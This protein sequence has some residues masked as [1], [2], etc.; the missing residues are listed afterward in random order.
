MLG[1]LLR[2]FM[3]SEEIENKNTSELVDLNVKDVIK[4]LDLKN[5]EVGEETEVFLKQLNNHEAIK[6]RK[7]MLNFYI[8]VTQYFQ[9]KLPLNSQNLRDLVALHPK[10]RQAKF[11]VRAI[12]RLARQLPHV[13]KEE[14][15]TSLRDEWKALQGEPVPSNW[16]ETGRFL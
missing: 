15:I 16:Y 5:I 13:I 2:R 14:E 6:L 8:A 4:Q 3:K 11:T 1:N 12:T 9:K 10:S 7:N